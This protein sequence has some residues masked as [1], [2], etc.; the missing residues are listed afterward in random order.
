MACDVEERLCACLLLDSGQEELQGAAK[1][2]GRPIKKVDGKT[3]MVG[4]TL[5]LRTATSSPVDDVRELGH[6]W[7]AELMQHSIQI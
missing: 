7:V 3:P 5:T 4:T 1:A 6:P 2:T